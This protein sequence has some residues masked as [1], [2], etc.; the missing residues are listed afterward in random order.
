MQ[1]HKCSV[2]QTLEHYHPHIA[3]YAHF[4]YMY[5]VLVYKFIIALQLNDQLLGNYWYAGFHRFHL[6]LRIRGGSSPSR[7]RP[8]RPAGVAVEVERFE[9]LLLEGLSETLLLSENLGFDV[10]FGLGSVD[11]NLILFQYKGMFD[12]FIICM[13]MIPLFF[14]I[15]FHHMPMQIASP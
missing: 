6:G 8:S 12:D 11:S 1:S 10:C 15:V 2:L 4:G 9:F 14:V 13:S 5:H 7:T 3:V